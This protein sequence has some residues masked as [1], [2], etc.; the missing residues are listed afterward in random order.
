MKLLRACHSVL[1]KLDAMMLHCSIL[2]YFFSDN[3]SL[4]IPE[5]NKN[6]SI[7]QVKRFMTKHTISTYFNFISI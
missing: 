5:M 2:F 6:W 4:A 3:V 7:F 1:I